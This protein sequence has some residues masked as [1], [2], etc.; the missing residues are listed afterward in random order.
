M[1]SKLVIVLFVLISSYIISN[2]SRNWHWWVYKYDK[3]GYHLY[4]PALYIY[5]DVD[6]LDF[7]DYINARYEPSG[8]VVKY[9]ALKF[10]DNG[11]KLNKY[12]VG[13][14]VLETPFFLIAHF[15]N[16]TFLD[17]AADGYS[18][19]YEWATIISNLIWT[20]IGLLILRRF[21]RRYFNDNITAITLAIIAL[22]TNLYHY[23]VFSPGMS[24]A[25]SFCFFSILLFHTDNLYTRK[26]TA[27]IYYLA[28][29]LGV[30]GLLRIPNLLVGI[31]PVLWGI[32]SIAT[33]K[34]RLKFL[35]RRMRHIIAGIVVFLL[36]MGIQLGYWKYV[37]GQWIYNSYGE[38]GFVWTD[39]E[40][41]KGVFGFQKGWLVYSPL[42]TLAL[43]GIY[44]MRKRF[45]ALIPIYVIFLLLNLYVVFSWYQWW[46][47]GGFG[48]RPL[49]ESLGVLALPLACFLEN[50]LHV[51]KGKKILL[52]GLGT[53]L[54]FFLGLNMFQS[55]QSYKNV[56]HWD[57]M[58]RA[59]YFRVFL[60]ANKTAEDEQ[61]LM[62]NE[63]FY[64]MILERRK[65]A[66][67]ED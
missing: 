55:Y 64:H 50:F 30:I 67:V 26:R 36:V 27:S 39:P 53:V 6:R 58:T 19:P 44:S 16:Q 18:Y 25:Y 22:G 45:K 28:I 40:I 33:I 49:I 63:D 21:L 54:I 60:K 14:A 2:T 37:T 11:K 42:V 1:K 15:I 29:T 17:Y 7:Y 34:E 12:S 8:N 9:Y 13:V 24:H 20:L 3:S 59:Y 10:F 47:G 5:N 4:M 32:N 31:V 57:H 48:A 65:A 46:Y 41:L 66:G 62:S 23:V 51:I 56:I 61:Y 35:S 38:E 52:L 43:I